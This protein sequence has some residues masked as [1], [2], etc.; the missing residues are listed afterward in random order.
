MDIIQYLKLQVPRKISIKFT[1][2]PGGICFIL[3]TNRTKDDA[4]KKVH[5][6]KTFGDKLDEFCSSEL[7]WFDLG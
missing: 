1:L 6:T 7:I 4:Y 3:K 2:C 5:L